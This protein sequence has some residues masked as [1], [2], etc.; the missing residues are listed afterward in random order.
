MTE[1]SR[2]LI[3]LDADGVLTAPRRIQRRRT[4]GWRLP[5]GTVYVGRP[6]R[7]GNPFRVGEP[8]GDLPPLTAAQAVTRYRRWL[9]TRD[10]QPPSAVDRAV[11]LASLHELRGRNLAC[12]CP[13]DAPCH[14]DV[15]LEMANA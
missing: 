12:W 7:F 2:P 1:T 11:I 13:L 4:A 8:R 10:S 9:E 3:L 14:A 5:E 15:L 6:T